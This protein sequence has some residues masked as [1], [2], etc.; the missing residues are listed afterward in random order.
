VRIPRGQPRLSARAPSRNAGVDPVAYEV[1]IPKTVHRIWLGS[2]VP[3]K[4]DSV[5]QRW[6][7]LFPD[8]EFK[9]WGERELRELGMPDYLW[10]ARTYPEQSDI[11]RLRVIN[12]CGGIYADCD[13]EPLMRFDDLWTS[14]DRL[15]V[16]E[17][18]GSE[19]LSGLF[20]G[21]PG[22]LDFVERFIARNARRHSQ[23]AAPN[24][25]TGPY[26]LDAALNYMASADATGIRGL[27]L[28]PPSFVDLRGGEPFAVIRT[29]FK[30]PPEWT[31]APET[32]AARPSPLRDATFD[33]RLLATRIRRVWAAR[34]R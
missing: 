27:R 4:F 19:I 10:T 3:A 23:D 26:A 12:R 21:S 31:R 15:V 30:S 29:R 17:A 32:Q 11:A 18:P 28:Y 25:R 9:T 5:W 1:V 6:H 16:F 13:C 2:A 34:G 7:D 22:S 14:D 20:A 8:Y 24:V 33:A